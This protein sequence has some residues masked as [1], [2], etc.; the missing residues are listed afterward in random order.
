MDLRQPHGC[1]ALTQGL[2]ALPFLL[3]VMASGVVSWRLW[4]RRPGTWWPYLLLL[5]I[6]VTLWCLGTLGWF[7]TESTEVRYRITQLQY[8]GIAPTPVLWLFTV[9]AYSGLQRWLTPASIA[10]LAAI[11][12]VTLLLAWTNDWHGLIWQRFET[13]P[14]AY[15]GFVEYGIWFEV[16]RVYNY[17]LMGALILAVLLQLASAPLYRIPLIII[18]LCTLLVI[19]ANILYHALE[20]GLPIDTTPVALALSF[21]VINWAIQH[22]QMF[23]LVPLARSVTLESLEDGLIVLSE[24]G[25]VV[26]I[27]PAALRLL[28]RDP[29]DESAAP[30]GT[31]LSTFMPELPDMDAGGIIDMKSLSGATLEVRQFAVDEDDAGHPRGEVLLLRDVTAMREA[32]AELARLNAQLEV[33]A[34]T[35]ALTG[36]PNRRRLMQRLEEEVARSRRYG[37]PLSVLLADLDHFKRIND[38]RGHTVGDQVLTRCGEALSALLRPADLAARCGGEEFAVILPETHLEGAIEAALRM[39]QRLRALEHL[40]AARGET[41][42]VTWSMGVVELGPGAPS[43]ETLLTRADAALYHTKATGRDGVSVIDGEKATRVDG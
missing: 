27:N 8:L 17:A 4:R 5:G 40:D 1:P 35:D 13:L 34:H 22:H 31:P 18:L 14:G 16:H 10:G 3:G 33:L 32:Q 15:R 24:S 30:L 2:L 20:P 29:D 41:F 9:L 37:S 21:I 7:L 28:G 42:Q 39:Q 11:P 23:E 19:A 43:G 26:D 25:H 6:C 36:L 12:L 38:T